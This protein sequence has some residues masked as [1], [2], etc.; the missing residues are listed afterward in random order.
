LSTQLK[1]LH[2]LM[3]HHKTDELRLLYNKR[4]LVYKRTISHAKSRYYENTIAGS[5]NAPRQIWK[6]VK[7]NLENRNDLRKITI[8][9][10]QQQI[11]ED[12]VEVA[13]YFGEHFSS[14]AQTTI[15]KHFTGDPPHRCT[16]SPYVAAT[17]F[18]HPTDEHEVRT[19]IL[20]LPSKKSTGP[21]GVSAILLSMSH[22]VFPRCLKMTSVIPILKKRD[23]ECLN[24]YRPISLLSIFSK[25]FEKLV[26]RRIMKHVT[27]NQILTDSQHG[28]RLGLSLPPTT[29]WRD[30]TK[31]SKKVALQ[32]PSSSM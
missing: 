22:G 12:D 7:Q 23:G 10:E 8:R 1:D 19:I 28:F 14:V 26:H 9:D 27:T 15:G 21:D 16:T 32:L 18:V 13:N 31:K 30:Y 4:K 11:I 17:M 5:S 24:N 6:I 29:L 25:L 3:M 20:D 2:R